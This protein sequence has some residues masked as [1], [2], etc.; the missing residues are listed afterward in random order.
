VYGQKNLVSLQAH[1]IYRSRTAVIYDVCCRPNCREHGPEE[2][3]SGHHIVFPRSG[4]FV[5]QVAGSEFV[6]DPNQVLFFNQAE[7]Y[8]IAHPVE[9]GDDC[10]VFEFRAELLR[11][12]IGVHQPKV[13]ER[14]DRPFEF[15][16]TLSDQSLFFFQHRVRQRLLSG[17]ADSLMI[18]E[19]A[20]ELLA[21]VTRRSYLH[22][23]VSPARRRATTAE[24]HREQAE[25]TRLLLAARLSENLGLE[26]IARAVH[27]S[28]FHL[29]RVFHGETG[30]AMHQYRNRLRLRVALERLLEQSTDLT[31]LAF[32]VGYSSHSH[33]SDAFR[34][35]FGIPPSECRR[36]ATSKQ[37]REMSKNLKVA[38][39]ALT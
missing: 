36:R 32:E 6:A 27:S 21:A 39:A 12:V 35:A 28:S 1:S 37:V 3:S 17:V 19:F 13:A 31:R 9:G 10:T 23:G 20:L 7:P 38:A 18:D 29:A 24:A 2:R 8:R 34:R 26:E 33:F 22:R 15:T 30:L 16:H 11:E 5:K 4:V 14:P 25:K